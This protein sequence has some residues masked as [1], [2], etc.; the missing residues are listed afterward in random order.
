MILFSILNMTCS[1]HFILEKRLRRM[2]SSR[3]LNQAFTDPEPSPGANTKVTM[4][5]LRFETSTSYQD[6]KTPQ[7]ARQA[8]EVLLAPLL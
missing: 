8:L 5:V 3:N 7:G 4:L 1:L 6:A 2:L